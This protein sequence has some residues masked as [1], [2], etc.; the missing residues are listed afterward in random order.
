[1]KKLISMLLVTVAVFSLAAASAS[2]ASAGQMKIYPAGT[3]VDTG[4]C[5]VQDGFALDRTRGTST[6]LYSREFSAL[7]PGSV[8]ASA[9][10]PF[11]TSDFSGNT[12][13]LQGSIHSK[14][15]YYSIGFATYNGSTGQYERALM[16]DDVTALKYSYTLDTSGLNWRENYY[17]VVANKGTIDMS[18]TL[19]VWG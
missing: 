19:Q 12:C 8:A 3:L 15:P 2:A 9:G 14:L 16:V 11:H 17:A 7:K 18:G 1:M 6:L 10:N 5:I 4:D 13:R